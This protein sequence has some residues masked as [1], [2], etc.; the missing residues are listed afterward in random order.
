MNERLSKERLADLVLNLDAL[1]E[2]LPDG[3]FFAGVMRRADAPFMVDSD[4]G[5][6]VAIATLEGTQALGPIPEVR[7]VG[8]DMVQ[9]IVDLRANLTET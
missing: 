9:A 8:R 2:V 6:W 5:K 4:H 3:W 1:Y 7:G